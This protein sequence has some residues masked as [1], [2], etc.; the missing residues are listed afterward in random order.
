MHI[1][2]KDFIILKLQFKL[3]MYKKPHILQYITNVMR[4]MLDQ[5][6]KHIVLFLG[7]LNNINK[8][9]KYYYLYSFSILGFT[10][11]FTLYSSNTCGLINIMINK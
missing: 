2:I 4:F 10:V 6:L 5:I 11:K 7:N 1:L 3:F 8:M 9:I